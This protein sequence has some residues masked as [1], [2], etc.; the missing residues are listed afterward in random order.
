[1]LANKGLCELQNTSNQLY[2]I[3]FIAL[4]YHPFLRTLNI[5]EHLRSLHLLFA[6]PARLIPLILAKLI[7]ILLESLLKDCCVDEPFPDHPFSDCAFLHR[8]HHHQAEPSA[9][10]TFAL[11]CT[12][13]DLTH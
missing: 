1:M 7:L 8:G 4:I 11:I 13:Y 10:H 12:Y 3:P 6:G 2:L 9:P 5:L